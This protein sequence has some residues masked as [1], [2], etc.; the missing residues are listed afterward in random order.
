MSIKVTLKT[1][2]TVEGELF[3]VDPVTKSVALKS[4]GAYIVLNP[5][6]ISQ[7]KGDLAA[8]PAPPLAALGLS[9]KNFEKK[10]A[11]AQKQTETRIHSL[12]PDVSPEVQTLYD[13]LSILYPCAWDGT[14]I[15]LLGEYAI[16][17]PYEKVTVLKGDGGVGLERL[18]KILE[19]ERKKL[20]L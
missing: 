8:Q 4:D 13:R 15:V 5:S 11:D 19:G 6:E 7:I 16:S 12:N 2:R 3:A 10:E 9:L 20:N 1:G 18:E 14:R 17:A